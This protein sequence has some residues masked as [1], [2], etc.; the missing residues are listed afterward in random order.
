MG[1]TLPFKEYYD[2]GYS[3]EQFAEINDLHIYNPDGTYSQEWQHYRTEWTYY[4]WEN[5]SLKWSLEHE[6]IQAAAD[7]DNPFVQDKINYMNDL[8]K[9]GKPPA[10]LIPI[11]EAGNSYISRI[12]SANNNV[13]EHYIEAPSSGTVDAI[14]Y[15]TGT[16]VKVPINTIVDSDGKTVIEASAGRNSSGQ[17]VDGVIG[18]ISSALAGIAVLNV[19]GKVVNSA[20]YKANETFW[21]KDMYTFDPDYIDVL[22]AGDKNVKA[23]LINAVFELDPNSDAVTMLLDD[24]YVANI[25]AYLNAKGWF[26]ENSTYEVSE[27]F[28]I[29]TEGLNSPLQGFD[30]VNMIINDAWLP[31]SYPEYGRRKGVLAMRVYKGEYATGKFVLFGLDPGT[32][33]YCSK[34]RD[35]V[36]LIAEIAFYPYHIEGLTD[37]PA[38]HWKHKAVSELCENNRTERTIAGKTYQDYRYAASTAQNAIFGNIG[39][40]QHADANFQNN[41]ILTDEYQSQCAI[42]H[43]TDNYDIIKDRENRACG[44]ILFGKEVAPEKIDGVRNAIG[45]NQEPVI[46][47]TNT[48]KNLKTDEILAML[49]STYPKLWTNSVT[50]G[51]L[52]DNGKIAKR[53]YIK[54]PVPRSGSAISNKPVSGDLV[55]QQPD[56]TTS[57]DK[58]SDEMAKTLPSTMGKPNSSTKI[59]NPTDTGTTKP[60][61]EPIG[62]A[63]S[64]WAVY[65]PT[66]NELQDFGAWMWS[67]NPFEQ[68]KKLFNDPMQ[69]IIGVHKVFVTPDDGG[70]RNIKVGYIDSGINSNYV[71][72]QYSYVDCGT[73]TLS[74]YFGNV[75]DYSPYTTVNI[76]LP[77]V[78]V[79]QL[80]TADVMRSTINVKYGVDVFTGDCLVTIRVKREGSDAILYSY[81][82]NCAVRYP[83]SSGSYM[84]ILGTVAGA[85]AAIYTGS[86]GAFGAVKGVFGNRP[87]VQHGGSFIGNSGATGP[88]TPYLIVSRPNAE[89]AANFNAIEG[90]PTNY[91]STIG[92]CQGFIRVKECHLSGINATDDELD[93]ID[94]ILKDGIIVQS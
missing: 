23:Y 32:W 87:T 39:V 93:M 45:L 81:P 88:K 30:E 40:G 56:A 43:D 37:M 67:D 91:T 49:Q 90:F 53:T 38:V 14:D 9:G 80:D 41:N 75:F 76:Y 94:Q 60:I 31:D 58:L 27:G 59:P 62:I 47:T 13:I 64:M 24:R 65:N 52:L 6:Q 79:I 84:S 72:L 48:K 69:A 57:W 44:I 11:T 73:V 74:E 1:K 15:S 77:F 68:I 26:A 85:A 16:T 28:S 29:S 86:V 51:V 2:A 12:Y 36:H 61:I 83:I 50:R 3:W 10:E 35:A 5:Q 78:G 63:K 55:H 71:A 70:R 54:V 42:I 34:D 8:L 18:T 92:N 82:G 33:H 4:N 19:L 7:R 46:F 21:G 66:E 20:I 25:A 17:A 89:L 22:Y